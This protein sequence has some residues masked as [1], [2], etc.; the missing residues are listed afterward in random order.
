MGSV[1]WSKRLT[2]GAQKSRNFS[3]VTRMPVGSASLN[4][5]MMANR[6]VILS[7]GSASSPVTSKNANFCG[8]VKYSWSRRKP[9]Y[10]V[11]G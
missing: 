8:R 6:S 4:W 9:G 11:F 3:R 5:M 10:T 1:A 7:V 2:T